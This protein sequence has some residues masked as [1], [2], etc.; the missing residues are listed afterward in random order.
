MRDITLMS[1]EISN[2]KCHKHLRMDFGGK[3]ATIYGDNATG[4]TSIY[5]SLVWLL[6]GKDS[7]GNGEKSID[8]KPLGEDGQVKDHEAITAVEAVLRCDGEDV[9]LK[10]TLREVWT[11]R[12][13]SSEMS[14]D[15]NVS[16]YFVDG[17]PSK[18]NAFDAKV[19]ELCPEDLFRMLTSVSWFASGMK[20][21]DRRAVLFDMAGNLT[22]RAIMEREERFRELAE[23]MGR[24]TVQEYKA[25][26]LH[27]K[28][29]LT[30]TRDDAPARISECQRQ[31]DKTAAVDEGSLRKQEAELI[32]VRDKLSGEIIA[33]EQD[34][35]VQAKRLDLLAA[36]LDMDQIVKAN[37]LHREAQKSQG[38]D[39]Q[40]LM[41]ELR[42]EEVRREAIEGQISRAEKS[43]I[44]FEDQL[45]QTRERWVQVNGEAFT[46]GICPSCGQALPFEKLKSATESFEA[47]K[48]KALRDIER[49]ADRIKERIQET[50]GEIMERKEDLNT[51]DESIQA[52]RKAIGSAQEVV[53]SD[54]PD[55]ADLVKA[56]QERIDAAQDEIRELNERSAE[57][58]A[59]KRKKMAEVTA[60]LNSIWE[61]MAQKVYRES[62]IKRIAELKDDMKTASEALEAIDR[63]LWAIEDFTRAKCRFVEESVN[64]LFN[65]ASFRLFREQANGGIEERCDAQQGGVPYMGLNNGMKINVGIDI[66]NALSRHYGVRVPLLVDNAEAVTKLEDC[67]SQVIRLVVSENDKELRMV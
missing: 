61:K 8:I 17:V 12:R 32:G 51:K 6:F 24:L 53:I 25:K 2:F 30:G 42:R 16:D 49:E 11:T 21:Q 4:K 44:R 40:Q 1:L 34:A 46:G 10:R 63:M 50:N 28:K 38:P 36:K 39:K 31:L 64:D 57:A 18:K 43:V 3:D 26:L 60:E 65:V 19:K 67:K 62:L 41:T 5:D 48:Q 13:G 58:V 9:T 56:A 29:G 23:S 59:G 14:Y 35:A 55:Y 66:I 52:I 54:M 33:M 7:L 22:D 45:Q 37:K 27:Q 47:K 20:W 15:G